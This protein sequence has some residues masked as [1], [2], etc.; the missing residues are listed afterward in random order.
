M[1]QAVSH[2]SLKTEARIHARVSPCGI[3]GGRSGIE[4]VSFSE[5]FGFLLS[6]SFY[7]SCPYWCIIW[8]MSNGFVGGRSSETS[9][10]PI[11]MNNMNTPTVWQ[12]IQSQA[13]YCFK[14]L[15]ISKK[16]D[17][18]ANWKLSCKN[19]KDNKAPDSAKNPKCNRKLAQDR[20]E[21]II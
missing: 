6:V 17:K 21:G 13:Y 8:G 16:K 9:S 5:F 15:T 2:R 1:T 19:K 20:K 4:T 3:C 12:C 7:H 10:Y 14:H 11:D 18:E